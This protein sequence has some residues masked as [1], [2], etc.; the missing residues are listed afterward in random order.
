[1]RTPPRLFGASYSVYVRIARL[2][3]AEKGVACEQV[4]VD[5][6]APEGPPP[7]YRERHPFGRI[8]AFEHDGFRLY[9]TGAIT[10]YVDEA[11]AGP[12]L[13]PVAPRARAR[14]NQLIGIADAYAYPALVWG[15]YV[16]R[17]EKPERDMPVNEAAIAAA[18]PPARICLAAMAELMGEG[19]WLAGATLSLAD[20]H[21]APMIDYFLK[22]PEG[23]AMLGGFPGLSDW[24][25]RLA[26]R[27]S[28]ALAGID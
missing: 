10:R 12:A 15:V 28:L 8:P 3:L 22:T 27:P 6:F 26:A 25:A 9:E 23:A 20:L 1:M 16:E 11:F 18:L 2:V 17:V 24:W 5:I 21:V 19:P 13:Q 7:D 4:P 14:M